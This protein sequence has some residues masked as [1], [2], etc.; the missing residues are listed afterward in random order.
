MYEVLPC[1]AVHRTDLSPGTRQRQDSNT[2]VHPPF[3]FSAAQGC[4]VYRVLSAASFLEALC[5]SRSL[6]LEL[7]CLLKRS[8]V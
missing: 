5:N 8:Q 6:Y 3:H 1:S 4:V 2:D 7:V